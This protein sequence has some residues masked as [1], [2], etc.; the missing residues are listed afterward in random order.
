MVAALCTLYRR[1]THWAHGYIFLVSVP[2]PVNALHVPLT[3]YLRM[4]GILTFKA[5]LCLT[6]RAGNILD[7]LVFSKH[8]TFTVWFGAVA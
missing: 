8:F 7:C 4:P 2:E 6:D 5:H 1:F 3:T